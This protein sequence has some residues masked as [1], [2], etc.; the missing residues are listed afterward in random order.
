MFGG[1]ITNFTIFGWLSNQ[2]QIR[3]GSDSILLLV[4]ALV[5]VLVLVFH[6]WKTTLES[7]GE[8][9][10]MQLPICVLRFEI[11]CNKRCS[12]LIKFLLLKP[13]FS[14]A[15]ENASTSYKVTKT[16]WGSQS[17]SF[18]DGFITERSKKWV[19]ISCQNYFCHFL[20]MYFS[21]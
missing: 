8:R 21:S 16:E 18:T 12:M 17:S 14:E 1:I 11:K 3:N 7:E 9:E 4:S 15:R 5:P 2:V 10:P 6:S 13:K 20:K 19:W